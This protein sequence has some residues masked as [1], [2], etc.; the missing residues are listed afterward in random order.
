MR[1]LVHLTT[2]SSSQ[3]LTLNYQYPLSAAIYKII[4]RSDEAYA[5]FL[6]ERGY[7]YRGKSFKFFTFSDLR[8][9]FFI[10]GDRLVMTTGTAS[11]TVCFHVPDAAENFIRGLFM[12]QQLQ[13]A[14]SR[15]KATFLV[16]QV[17]AEKTPVIANEAMLLQTMS[18]LVVGRKNERGN[19][20]YTYN[21]GHH[22]MC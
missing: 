16:Q 9:P 10:K 7:L 20:D 14:D 17:I 1:F 18:P 4:H 19:Y 11:F 12:D 15:D 21:I 2:Q 13:I 6:H 8:T 3:R 22:N 5:S